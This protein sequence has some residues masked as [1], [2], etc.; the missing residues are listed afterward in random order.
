MDWYRIFPQ[1]LNMSLTADIVILFILLARISMKKMPKKYSYVLWGVVLFRLL[2]PV[3]ITSDISLL[4]FMDAPS[5][6]SGNRMS[7]VEYVPSDIVHIENPE[8]NLPM[9]DL[10]DSI[11]ENLPQGREQPAADPLEFPISL[12]TYIWLTGMALMLGYSMISYNK[13]KKKLVGAIHV[14]DN[15]Y[16]ADNISSPFVMGIFRPRIYLLSSLEEQEQAYIMLHEQQHICRQDHIVKILAYVA[17]CIHWFNPLVWVAFVLLSKDME[18]SCDEAV[19][20]RLGEEIRAD[21]SASLLS[22]SSSQRIAFTAPLAFGEGDTKGRIHNLAKWKKPAVWVTMTAAIACVCIIWV[23]MS[24]PEGKGSQTEDPSDHSNHSGDMMS[25]ETTDDVLC[26]VHSKGLTSAIEPN[27]Y[28]NGFDFKYENVVCG[29]VNG[30]G[31]LEFTISWET[32]VLT[33][34]EDYYEHSGNSVHIS[35]KTYELKKNEDGI[36]VLNVS[37]RNNIETEE[38]F[39]FISGEEG[40]YVMK[41]AFPIEEATIAATFE[42]TTPEN[43]YDERVWD[44]YHKMSDGT[45]RVDIEDEDGTVETFSYQ[46][47]IVVHGRMPNAAVDINYILLSNITDITFKQ[48]WMASGFSSNMSDYFTKDEAVFVASWVGDLETNHPVR[49]EDTIYVIELV[50]ESVTE[51]NH[52]WG[53]ELNASDVRPT[54]L[55]IVCTQS[56]G[57]PSGELQTGSYYVVEKLTEEGWTP[58]D[59]TIENVAWDAVAWII[60]MEESVEWEV[61]REWLYGKL[62]AGKYRIGKEIMDFRVAGNYDKA[63]FYAEFYL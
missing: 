54:G 34:G 32:N 50:A 38:A 62:P 57:N 5:V 43:S 21:Y 18:M 48:T 26:T 47:R 8:V 7:V 55:K 28:P 36:F 6:S 41:I 37:R 27:Y 53:I 12:G 35:K 52:D 60:P 19:I 25:Y 4:G 13:L 22:F 2:C 23:S 11:N 56:G 14:R 40:T 45:W 9:T 61:D 10:D 16:M 30:S 59:H 42:K 58:V 33:V 17:L 29:E 46:Y 3:S 63:M 49:D 39:Y 51:S 15:I 1:I 24:N 20:S 31:E 44:T